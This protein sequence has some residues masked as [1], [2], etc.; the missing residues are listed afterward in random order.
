MMGCVIEEGDRRRGFNDKLV[1]TS[2]IYI[3][4]VVYGLHAHQV[5]TLF[6]RSSLEMTPLCVVVPARARA[7]LGSSEV[8]WCDAMG[9]AG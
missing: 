9:T 7:I 3:L 4:P 5:G 1:W 8:A 2:L 6:H